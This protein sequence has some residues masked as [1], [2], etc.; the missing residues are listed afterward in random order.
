MVS[1]AAAGGDGHRQQS[2]PLDESDAAP[3]PTDTGAESGPA[4]KKRKVVGSGRGVANLNP[5]QLAKKRA[6]GM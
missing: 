4:T 1:Q 5:E 3:T 6:N 2:R